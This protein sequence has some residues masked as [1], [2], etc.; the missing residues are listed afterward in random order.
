MH[1]LRGHTGGHAGVT[2][3]ASCST[4][5]IKCTLRLVAIVIAGVFRGKV[6]IVG[7]HR[8]RH[9]LVLD[10]A[11]VFDLCLVRVSPF[12]LQILRL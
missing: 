6:C 8:R 10:E 7:P 11:E 12:M 9:S 5:L 2:A 1:L 4:L 3:S